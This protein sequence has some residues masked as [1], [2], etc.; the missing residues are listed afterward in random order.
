MAGN[1]ESKFAGDGGP[2]IAASLGQPDGVAVDR[3]GTLYIADT[4]SH[5]IRKITADGI[6]R[7]IAGSDRFGSDGDGGPATLAT[8]INPAAAWWWIAPETWCLPIPLRA[9]SAGLRPR[10]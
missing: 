6:I 10:V 3:D 8:L 2:A 1:G 4:A 7:T 9:W 5:R